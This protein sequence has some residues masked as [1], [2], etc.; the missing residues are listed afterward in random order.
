MLELPVRK[1]F[2]EIMCEFEEENSSDLFGPIV[3]ASKY[4][5][6]FTIT[7]DDQEVSYFL[8]VWV[9]KFGFWLEQNYI[10]KRAF[11]R[12]FYRLT[13]TAREYMD[14]LVKIRRIEMEEEL[15]KMM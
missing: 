10:H 11:Y 12:T 3:D 6:Y 4:G 14:E 1:G 9:R 15:E 13:E 8:K 2:F 5:H 7:L